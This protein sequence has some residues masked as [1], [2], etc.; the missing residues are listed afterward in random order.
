MC[1]PV[2]L[3]RVCRP[4]KLV[5]GAGPDAAGSPAQSVFFLRDNFS[6][7]SAYRIK[8]FGGRLI[9]SLEPWRR[10][11]DFV[12]LK[13]NSALLYNKGKDFYNTIRI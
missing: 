13:S 1:R 11:K 4:E 5:A 9:R 12:D 7:D 2:S 8:D 6:L 3:T 10:A